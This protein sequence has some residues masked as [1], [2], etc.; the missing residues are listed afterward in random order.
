MLP[1]GTAALGC[2]SDSK[3]LLLD[4]HL[5]APARLHFR[6][7]MRNHLSLSCPLHSQLADFGL[8]RRVEVGTG[9]ADADQQEG[10]VM[11]PVRWTAP[12]L[13]QRDSGARASER[14]D[15]W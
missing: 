10:A 6:S 5:L 1:D 2:H 4:L 9:M 14:T 15:I 7:A 8:S 3:L 12:E 11:V 13:L